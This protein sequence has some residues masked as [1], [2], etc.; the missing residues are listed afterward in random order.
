M[1]RR[2]YVLFDIY[3]MGQSFVNRRLKYA[4]VLFV[5][6]T[7]VEKVLDKYPEEWLAKSRRKA[8]GAPSI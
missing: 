4:D 7:V 1:D 2:G 8:L 5:S 3:N 6:P